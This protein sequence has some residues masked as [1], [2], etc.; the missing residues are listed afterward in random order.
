MAE[1]YSITHIHRIFFI[2]SSIDGYLGCSHVLAIVNSAAMNIGVHISF[3]ITA[4]SEYTP[5]NGIVGSYN[6]FIFSFL[7]KL[8]TVFHSGCTRL[9]SYQQCRRVSFSPH[10]LQHLLFVDLLIVAILACVRWYL[11]VVLI[12][13]S[14]IIKH[15]KHLFRCP[16]L[17]TL[18]PLSVYHWNCCSE[19]RAWQQ[20]ACLPQSWVPLGLTVKQF[21]GWL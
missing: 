16:C 15:V 20:A 11:I 14:L 10:S 18:S 8:P 6:S 7:R 21:R 12:S 1:L 17:P 3:P 5:R 9:H 2:R 19:L 4:V 13:I